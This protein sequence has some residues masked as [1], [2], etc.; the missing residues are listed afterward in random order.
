MFTTDVQAMIPMFHERGLMYTGICLLTQ[1]PSSREKVPEMISPKQA[2][3][4]H[5]QLQDSHIALFQQ[6]LGMF[7]VQS[8]DDYGY[9][10]HNTHTKHGEWLYITGK[11]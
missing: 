5:F 7:T 2:K 9:A 3:K 1:L 4:H 11:T 6:L 10:T 8:H